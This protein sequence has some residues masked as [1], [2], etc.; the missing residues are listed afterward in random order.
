MYF[1]KMR[2]NYFFLKKIFLLYFFRFWD[3]I[4]ETSLKEG[5]MDEKYHLRF[6]ILI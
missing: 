5:I 1:L 2:L 4:N 6:V 3:L